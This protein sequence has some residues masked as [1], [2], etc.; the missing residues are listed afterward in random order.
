MIVSSLLE[1]T[2]TTPRSYQRFD[3]DEGV[4][5]GKGG[6]GETRMNR[7]T[8]EFIKDNCLWSREG[9]LRYEQAVLAGTK[10]PIEFPTDSIEVKAVWIKLQN[11]HDHQR[12]YV[13][14]HE[15]EF[16]GLTSFHILTRDVPKWFWATFHHIDAPEN[17][18]ELEDTYG[19]PPLV[20]GT[21]WEK[22]CAGRHPSRFCR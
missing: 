2:G 1:E 22:L 4:F 15:G 19:P 9:L 17:K 21:V 14:E 20:T 10:P 13:A 11:E 12:Y 8:Y 3:P 18:F 16:Y 5:H 7:A 6:L